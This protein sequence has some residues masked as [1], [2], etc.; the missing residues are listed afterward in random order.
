MRN[1]QPF[2]KGDTVYIFKY[3]ALGDVVRTAYFVNQ[4]VAQKEVNVTWVTLTESIPLIRFNPYVFD[5]VDQRLFSPAICDHVLSLDDEID[6]IE[7]A[8]SM[9]SKSYFGTYLDD[10]KRSYTRASSLWNDMGLLSRFNK[11]SADE[12]KLLNTKGH[13]EI[14][15]EML[16][17][18][19]A[20]PSFYGDIVLEGRYKKKFLEYDFVIG[21]N[22]Y[23]GA[24]WPGKEIPDAELDSLVDSLLLM[25]RTIYANPL[26]VVFTD[27]RNESRAHKTLPPRS[28][29]IIANTGRSVLDFAALISRCHCLVTVDSLGLH[30]AVS[31]RIPVVACFTATSAAE[32][33]D[34]GSMKKVISTSVDYC[35]YQPNADNSSITAARILDSVISLLH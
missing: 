5:I 15:C 11:D 31:Q 18:N 2:L 20:Q 33:D 35:S 30:L 26:L 1:L 9:E 12:L 28:G 22:P 24:R 23:A 10:G 6:S 16:G 21:V 7:M 14:F 4:L 3:G 27:S 17:L 29:L 13:S 8:Q 19:I 34:F 32:I 25:L